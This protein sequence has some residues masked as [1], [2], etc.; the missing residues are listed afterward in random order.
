[1]HVNLKEKF[2][3][4]FVATWGKVMDLDRFDLA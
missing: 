4:Y 3:N 1:V 2:V